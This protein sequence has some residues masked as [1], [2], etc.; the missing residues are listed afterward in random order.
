MDEIING[1]AQQLSDGQLTLDTALKTAY[2]KIC[3]DGIATSEIE[4]E[5]KLLQ[6]YNNIQGRST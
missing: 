3:A 5:S 1:I 6:A 2:D 4:V